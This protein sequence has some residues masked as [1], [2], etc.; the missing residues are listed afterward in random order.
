MTIFAENVDYGPSVSPWVAHVSVSD[1]PEA[2][3]HAQAAFLDCLSPHRDA[4]HLGCVTVSL[5]LCK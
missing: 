2:G 1:R 3:H 4:D 5:I